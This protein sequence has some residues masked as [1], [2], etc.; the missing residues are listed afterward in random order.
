MR[1]LIGIPPCLDEQGR[2]RPSREYHYADAAY[3][4]AVACSG[5]LPVYL[6]VQEDVAALADR[7][8]GLLLPGGGDFRPDR[9]Y[10]AG[11]AFDPVPERQL[12]FD[13]ALLA[14]AL[15]RDRPVLAICYGMQLLAL[16]CGGALHFDLATDVPG[17]SEH[18]FA[19]PAARH[20]IRLEA[21]SRLRA[22]LGEGV[23]GVNSRH[24]QSVADAGRGRVSARTEDGVVEAIEL[25]G[26]R[27]AVGVQW[28]PESLDPPHRDRLFGAF[29]RACRSDAKPA[30]DGAA[31][32]GY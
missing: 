30:G 2:W 5:G 1:P 15:E 23:L 17:A 26:A 19:D 10:P 7:L 21:T 20:P 9:A 25:P 27:F 4:N 8:D 13:R 12:A 3:A 24:H 11:V 29:V 14:A 32:P 31:G 18:R 28:H 16:H 6:P 22:L